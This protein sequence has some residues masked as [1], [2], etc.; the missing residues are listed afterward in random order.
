MHDSVLCMCVYCH[1]DYTQ[2]QFADTVISTSQSENVT[3]LSSDE[4]VVRKP[5]EQNAQSSGQKSKAGTL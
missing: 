3:S 4:V 5:R 2:A 1:H